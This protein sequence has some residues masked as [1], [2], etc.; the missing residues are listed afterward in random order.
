MKDLKGF[1]F[2]E[3]CT[4]VRATLFGDSPRLEI[5]KVTRIN[6]GKL[7]L[8]DSKQPIRFPER[9]LIIDQDRLTR[10]VLEY[11]EIAKDSE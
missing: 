4:V 11:D 9:L 5:S 2:S 6:E 7:Y 3:G 10:M 1:P 8:N